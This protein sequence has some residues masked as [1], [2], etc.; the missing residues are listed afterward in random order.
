MSALQSRTIWIGNHRTSV[1]LHPSMWGAL[2]EIAEREDQTVHDV[3]MAIDRK[4]GATS[5]STA[6][7]VYIVESLRVALKKTSTA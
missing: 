7:H 6:I 3:L 4:R 2:G 5:L 1:R